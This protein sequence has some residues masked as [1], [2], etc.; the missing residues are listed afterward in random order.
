MFRAS[1]EKRNKSCFRRVEISMFERASEGEPRN[2]LND[3]IARGGIALVFTLA[4]LDK[5]SDSWIRLFQQI[6]FG[7]WF[8]YFTGVVELMGSLL[9]L[10]PWTEN[11][12]LALLSSIMA[13]AALLLI[14]VVGRPADSIFPEAI[15]V[16]LAA[17]WWNRRTN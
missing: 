15:L 8:R 5:F 13:S 11:A 12:G 1:N 9:V 4:G 3:W 14:F 17:F 16:V 6:G 7:Q 2:A 10:I